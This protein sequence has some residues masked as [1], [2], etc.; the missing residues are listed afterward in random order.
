MATE[1]P[2]KDAASTAGRARS[3]PDGEGPIDYEHRRAVG[4]PKGGLLSGVACAIRAASPKTSVY[5]A[6]PETAAPLSASFTAG[7]ASYFDGWRA[8]FVDGAGGRSVLT[9]MWPL[10][11]DWVDESLIVSLDDAAAAMRLTADRVHVIAEGAAA[12][13]IAAAMSPAMAA[14][15]HKKVVAVVSGGNIDLSRFAQLVG[16]CPAKQQ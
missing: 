16:A 15:G 12:C 6:E 3:A 1:A 8:S 2:V 9:T 14:K 10:L 4:A 11:K 7:R 5:A 13:A